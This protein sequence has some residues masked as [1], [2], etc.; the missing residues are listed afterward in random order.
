MRWARRFLIILPFVIAAVLN[1]L[2]LTANRFRTN[3]QHIEGY[4]FLFAAP[5]GWIVDRGWFENVH[6]RPLT[7]LIGY[8]LI[9]WIPATLYS[10]CLW[11][12]MNGIRTFA[13]RRTN[14][15]DRA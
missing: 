14:G 11:L 1:V 9:L 13:A 8:A 2:S 15:R 3:S 4:G 7:V 10:V 5:W 6:S 12:V